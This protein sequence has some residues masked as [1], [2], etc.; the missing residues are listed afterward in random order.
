MRHNNGHRKLSRT[1]EHRRALLRNMATSLIECGQYR[2]TE[3]K[4]KE[5]RGV[6]EKLV[7]LARVDSVANRRRAAAYLT[8]PAAVRK[9]FTEIAPK[10]KGR[11]GGYTRVVKGTW[12]AG[13]AAPVA[14]I[15]FV[16]ENESAA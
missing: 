13:D 12:R 16:G 2:T 8:K 11:N 10:F 3:A 1:H 5:L 15:A 14:Y 9:L 6:V 7:T 4:A